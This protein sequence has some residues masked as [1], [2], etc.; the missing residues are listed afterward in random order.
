[1]YLQIKQNICKNGLSEQDWKRAKRL[2]Y[3]KPFFLFYIS[4][5]VWLSWLKR[6]VHIAEIPGSNPGA[7][8]FLQH[9]LT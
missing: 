9:G 6:C 4:K 5:G 1:V 7:P 2:D 3:L 8:R